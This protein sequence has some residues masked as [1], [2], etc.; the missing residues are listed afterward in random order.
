MPLPLRNHPGVVVVALAVI[1]LLIWG[2]WP[3]SVLVEAVAVKRAPLTVTIEEEGRTRVIDRFIISAPVDGMACR[4]QL[5]VGD[6]VEQGQ[7]LLTITP[8]EPQVL[9]PRRRA[10]AEARVAAAQAALKSARQRAES[11]KASSAFH[12]SEL[13]RL[14]PLLEKGV[15]SQGVFDKAE[16]ERLTAKA[17][18]RAADHT[19]EVATYELE[20]T[21]TALKYSAGT[22]QGEP[23]V[24]V[25]VRSPITGKILKI[26]R[27]CEG[28]VRTGETLLEVG[29]PALLEVEV[30]VL[31]ADA[32]KI[33][34]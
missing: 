22:V 14:R 34:P 4:V 31:S 13:K 10:E 8:L 25:P 23:A 16:M 6:P 3:Q 24:R 2:F 33:K 9:D 32:V 30:D 26:Q 19:L 7:I 1:G 5:D 18:L 29:D 27:E 15:I 17:A 21:E 11:A 20:A 28:P 12:T